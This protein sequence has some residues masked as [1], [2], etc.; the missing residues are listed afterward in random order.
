MFVARFNW[1]LEVAAP[2]VI[3]LLD[4]TTVDDATPVCCN[5]VLELLVTILF[6]TVE[7]AWFETVWEPKLPVLATELELSCNVRLLPYV[8]I[9][10]LIFELVVE[11]VVPEL[12]A[13]T[14]SLALLVTETV[15]VK[16]LAE[17]V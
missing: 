14:L 4:P 15:V 10:S 6:P 7:V 8:V 16:I 17:W 2:T 12:T 1:L 3:P 13:T 5:C 9:E 11:T